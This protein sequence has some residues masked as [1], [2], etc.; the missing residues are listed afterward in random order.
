MRSKHPLSALALTLVLVL[1]LGVVFSG[2]AGGQCIL[3]NPSFEIAG[4]GGAT[5]GGWN[6]FGVI[7][8]VTE[9]SHGSKAA[10]V[11][12]PDLG[13]WDVSGY[14]QR[15]DC[16]PGEQW[17]ITGHVR[18]PSGNPLTG[19]CAAIVNVEWR[20]SGDNL[21][22]YD[23][24]TVANSSSPA[25]EYLD[26]S[27]VSNPAPTG[28]VAAHFL[29]G[30]LQSPTDPSPD[31]YY[32]QVTFFSTSPPTMDDMQWDDFPGGRTFQFAGRTWRVKGPGYYGPGPSHFCDATDCVWVDGT[33]RL[34]LT[35]KY[36]NNA[37]RST[38]VVLDEALGYG[39]YIFTTEGDL[40][41]LD[42]HAVLGLFIWQYG[43]CYDPAYMW[44]NPFDEFDIE[45]SR[46]GYA[47]ND[48]GQFVAQ[49]WDWP[50]NRNRFDATFSEGEITSHAFLWL[51]DRLEC[52]SWRGGPADEAPENMIHEW[53]YTGPH[54]PRPEQPRVHINL[55]QYDG[56]PAT[57]QEVIFDDFT[58]IP[59]GATVHVG[60]GS[61]G[62][63]PASPAGRLHPAV[64][65][66]F[67][68]Q[69][70]IRFDLVRD[71]IVELE[72]YDLNGRLVRSLTN[73]FLTAGE[74]RATWDGRDDSSRSLAS[75]VYLILLRG[76][77]FV[78]TRRMSLV[79]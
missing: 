34:H 17:E 16:G 7:G 18:H 47:G 9:A 70:I 13:G 2:Q 63:L 74:H 41:L 5:F 61:S 66:P 40:D 51:P 15:L 33:D 58:F 28:T 10:R 3:S 36:Y 23:S 21:I 35:I 60:D 48:I 79:K 37:W 22:D 24:F 50:G 55:W 27:L 12:G 53:T 75:G 20:D 64:P 19:Q 52:R 69:T 56:P 1:S 77:D 46:W 38:E 30:V 62:E 14:W 67:N 57:E 6:Q 76:V 11:S 25:D 42:I 68:P 72:V 32:D 49:P 59:A 8:S 65:N 26:F 29:L 73:G 43:P 54:I 78:E 4:S 31:V 39:D 44:W 71:G 45:F